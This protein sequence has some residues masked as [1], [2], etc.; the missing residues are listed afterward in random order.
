MLCLTPEM[1]VGPE[2]AANLE[3][4]CLKCILSL[5]WGYLGLTP[6]DRGPLNYNDSTNISSID[7]AI[8]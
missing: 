2:R 1:R 4:E 3:S 8:P 5:V 7:K 6:L